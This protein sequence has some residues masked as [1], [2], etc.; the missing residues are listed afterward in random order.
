MALLTVNMHFCVSFSRG[1]GD[2]PDPGKRPPLALNLSNGLD[3]FPMPGTA[4][5]SNDAGYP[6]SRLERSR[7]HPA[8]DLQFPV[9]F[10]PQPASKF[11][12]CTSKPLAFSADYSSEC[13]T[14]RLADRAKEVL[15]APRV[16]PLPHA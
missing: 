1:Y 11:R 10:L 3:D 12:I 2:V 9:S 6:M 13:K 16:S 14:L 8:L 7:F 5:G 15:C 4:K